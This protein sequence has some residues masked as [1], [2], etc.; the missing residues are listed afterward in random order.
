MPRKEEAKLQDKFIKL[1]KNEN[2]LHI[3]TTGGLS[4]LPNGKGGFMPIMN[5]KGFADIIV[6][7]DNNKTETPWCCPTTLFIEMKT[8]T[9]KLRNS[10]IENFNKCKRLGFDCYILRPKHWKQ[11]KAKLKCKLTFE[12]VLNEMERY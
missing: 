6:F 12:N 4:Y 11:A 2:I 7:I 5:K 8:D 9:S 1:L 10:Q 3:K